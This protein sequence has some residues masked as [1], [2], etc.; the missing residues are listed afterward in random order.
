MRET[1]DEKVESG[2][3]ITMMERAARTEK[4]M[5]MTGRDGGAEAERGKGDVRRKEEKTEAEIEIMS[6]TEVGDMEGN[7]IATET[8]RCSCCHAIFCF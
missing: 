8:G 6:M 7:V 4:E 3:E 1:A 2:A 5:A